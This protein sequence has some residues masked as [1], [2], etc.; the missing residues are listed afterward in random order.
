M[1][2]ANPNTHK[3]AFLYPN[4]NFNIIS[5]PESPPFP[6][7]IPGSRQDVQQFSRQIKCEGGCSRFIQILGFR[8]CVRL[9]KT[10][11]SGQSAPDSSSHLSWLDLS[12]LEI[13]AWKGCKK[14][15]SGALSKRQELTPKEEAL[16]KDRARS[17]EEQRTSKLPTLL[18][19]GPNMQSFGFPRFKGHEE[20]SAPA[21][22][23]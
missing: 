19:N 4:T 15:G 9:N 8:G 3:P 18:A 12:L 23:G 7:D 6:P 13:P 14:P 1:D 22:P 17:S 16:F 2:S 11:A 5:M 20:I 21:S 10:T